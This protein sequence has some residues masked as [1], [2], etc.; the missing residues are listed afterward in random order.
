[1]P[2]ISRVF[3]HRHLRASDLIRPAA[4]QVFFEP[5]DTEL[6]V[7][8]AQDLMTPGCS[9]LDL[10]SG[11]G[12]AAAAI[13][14]AGAARVHGIDDCAETVAWAS[15]HYA[16][17]DDDP[18]VTFARGNFA[19]MSSE[20]LLATVPGT[21]PRPLVVTS[22]PPYVPL[23]AR[24]A[25]L[26][27]SISGGTDGLRW[28]SAIIGH[29][30]SLQTDLGFTIGSYS[31]PR[32]A[33]RLLESAGYR[34]HAVTLCPLP[35]GA[36]TQDNMEQVLALEEQGEAVLWRTAPKEFARDGLAYFIVG[37]ACHWTGGANDRSADGRPKENGLT[38]EGLLH[39]LRTAARSHV[40]R[41]EALDERLPN[42]WA[43]PLRVL[44]LPVPNERHHW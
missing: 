25:E 23:T 31:S 41:L 40:P 3:G 9:V 7:W 2:V 10:G 8:V 35:L 18:R 4:A 14:R 36:F 19:A 5:P 21:L 34:V 38:G 6:G 20:E 42:G 1:M 33:V 15:Q 44:D 13:A 27:P 22:N 16:S 12:A 39:L 28:A 29:A 32:E 43:G 26:R 37:L 11:S 17:R 24:A 30:R